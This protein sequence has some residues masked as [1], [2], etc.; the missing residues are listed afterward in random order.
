MARSKQLFQ[1]EQYIYSGF[2]IEIITET[3][4]CVVA[5]VVGPRADQ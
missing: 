2:A 3:D 1:S 5:D 4:S